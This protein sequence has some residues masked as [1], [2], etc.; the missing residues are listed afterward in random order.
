M[1]SL[2]D[3]VAASGLAQYAEIALVIF[4]VVFMAIALRVL[5]MKRTDLDRMSRL[6]LDDD[7]STVPVR[8]EAAL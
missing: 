7:T 3:V 1:K 2:S 5:F 6:P 4:F 8:D